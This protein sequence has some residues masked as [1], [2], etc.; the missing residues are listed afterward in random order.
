M[1]QQNSA[2]SSSS[3]VAFT[4]N[5]RWWQQQLLK[6]PVA[7]MHHRAS[8]QTAGRALLRTAAVPTDLEA[9][10]ML[11]WSGQILPNSSVLQG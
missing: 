4:F 5:N 2:A 8:V 11:L 10:A 1:W 9:A 3:T 6:Q 7:V